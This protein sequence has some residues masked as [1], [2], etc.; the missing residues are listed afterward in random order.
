MKF[1]PF[2]HFVEKKVRR[3]SILLKFMK[4]VSEIW[5]SNYEDFIRLGLEMGSLGGRAPV[6]NRDFDEVLNK[7]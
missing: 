2:F 4:I 5:R 6:E 7:N 1:Q 3:K